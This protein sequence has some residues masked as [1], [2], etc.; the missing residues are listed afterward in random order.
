LYDWGSQVGVTPSSPVVAVAGSLD[1]PGVTQVT[2]VMRPRSV[3]EQDQPVPV[4]HTIRAWVFWLEG[5]VVDHAVGVDS[6]NGLMVR[7]RCIASGG[8]MILRYLRSALGQ[9]ED[10]SLDD[11]PGRDDEKEVGAFTLW[12]LF[13]DDKACWNM[14]VSSEC[15]VI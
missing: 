11:L 2:R 15:V 1:G 3:E 10:V 9:R 14:Y 5:Q 8:E 13:D 4:S 12:S 6:D 7:A